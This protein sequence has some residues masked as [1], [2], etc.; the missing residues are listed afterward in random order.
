M[1]ILLCELSWQLLQHCHTRFS[2]KEDK[3]SKT[4]HQSTFISNPNGKTDD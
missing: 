2:G 1:Y 4:Q 3:D